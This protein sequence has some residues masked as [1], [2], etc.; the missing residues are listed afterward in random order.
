MK[1]NDQQN[2]VDVEKDKHLKY[3][4]EVSA[5][6]LNKLKDCTGKIGRRSHIM[7]RPKQPLSVNRSGIE[8]RR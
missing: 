3:E 8:C 5:T 2:R 1:I 4:Q 6:S 7:F